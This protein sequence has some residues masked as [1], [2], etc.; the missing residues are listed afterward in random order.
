MNGEGYCA[1]CAYPVDPDHDPEAFR[2]D[3]ETWCSEACYARG[4]GWMPE[5]DRDENF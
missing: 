3:G 1:G 5:A 2:R 4:P